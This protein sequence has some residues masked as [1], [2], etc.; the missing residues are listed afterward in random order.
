[1]EIPKPQVLEFVVEGCE[2]DDIARADEELP[3]SVDLDRDAELLARF[4][5]DPDALM[6]QFNG[7]A[8]R[9][10]SRRNEKA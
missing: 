7:G 4:G 8:K 6:G 9:P 5:V 3:D 1:M 10:P 2:G